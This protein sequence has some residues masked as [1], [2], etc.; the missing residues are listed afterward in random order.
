MIC[1]HP[2]PGIPNFLSNSI[3]IHPP[4]SVI[5]IV[6]NSLLSA[7]PQGLSVISHCL[8]LS[9]IW[10]LHL[11]AIRFVYHSPL[12]A[13]PRYVIHHCLSYSIIIHPPLSDN[14]IVCN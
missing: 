1:L 8:L 5:L 9:F 7:I 13:I 12:Y 14:P 3:D 10:Y 2:S 11:F 6:C 4:L